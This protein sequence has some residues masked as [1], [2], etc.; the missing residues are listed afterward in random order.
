MDEEP[1]E[2]RLS[3]DTAVSHNR[4]A[5]HTRRHQHIDAMRGI[6]AL[7]VVYFHIALEVPPTG[8]PLHQIER[9]IFF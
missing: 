8:I 6:A 2:N 7:A 4:I 9:V 5:P 3:A 1:W